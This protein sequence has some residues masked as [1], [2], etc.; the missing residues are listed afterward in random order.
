MGVTT[1]GA[2]GFSVGGDPGVV[3]ARVADLRVRAE[4]F[5]AV[6][7]ALASVS[8]SGWTGRAADRFRERF[9]V[10]PARWREA[11]SGFYA[12]A[13]GLSWWAV[14]LRWGKE[15]AQWCRNEWARGD[16]VS[17]SARATYDA[18]VQ[19]GR[20]AKAR[21]E[22]EHGPDTYTLT[23]EPFVDPG[24]AVRAGAQAE[25]DRVVGIL[26]DAALDVAADVRRGCANAPASRNWLESG[27]AFV[28]GI[29]VGAGEAIWDLGAML[30]NLQYGMV[31]DLVD[32]AT[33]DLT[34]EELAAKNQLKVEQAQAMWTALTDDPWAFGM[35]VGK[36]VL[37]WD[38]WADDPARA[39]GHLVPDAIAA[40]F[41]GGG[42]AIATR[43]GSALARLGLHADDVLD[44]VGDTARVANRVDD[45]ADLRRLDELGNLDDLAKPPQG[46]WRDP[47]TDAQIDGWVDDVVTAHPELD[48]A[49]VKAIWDYSTDRGYRDMNTALRGAGPVD[50]GVTQ[51]IEDLRAGLDSLPATSRTTYRGT[52]LPQSVLDDIANGGRLTDP[53]FTSSSTDPRVADGFINWGKDNPVRIEVDGYSGVDIRPFSSMQGEV[54][55]LFRDGVEFDVVGR[56]VDPDGA[57]HLQVR[58]V[59]R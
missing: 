51:R 16:E 45:L 31:F 41:T 1:T 25:F 17:R 43:G 27:L 22:G 9:D 56:W 29:I 21:W 59:P 26:Q 50:P 49:Q 53:A 46:T 11:G 4:R 55:V 57:L 3:D 6:G 19:A 28:G 54:E 47:L 58:E 42:S 30:I 15:Q 24:E 10:E 12:A 13:S 36:A 40:V 34:V 2:P 39:I 44:A 18:D 33:G 38:T 37:D 23:I 14:Q 32:L 52:N 8:T 7:D 35:N 5:T 20:Q 48:R